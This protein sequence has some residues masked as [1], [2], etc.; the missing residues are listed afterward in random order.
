MIN[1][2]GEEGMG[3]SHI[4]HKDLHGLCPMPAYVLGLPYAIVT[5]IP[6]PT[7]EEVDLEVQRVKGRGETLHISVDDIVKVLDSGEEVSK[8]IGSCAHSLLS[9][10][11]MNRFLG[12]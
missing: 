1:L 5:L 10:P 2:A 12:Y 9:T 4:V 8:I 3:N 6:P 7:E 11:S